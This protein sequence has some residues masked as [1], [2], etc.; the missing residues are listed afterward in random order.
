MNRRFPPAIQDPS[1]R[2]A[3]RELPAAALVLA[4]ASAALWQA[5]ADRA[6][7]LGLNAMA[8][9]WLPNWAPDALTVL[10]HGALACALVAPFLLIEPA[11]ALGVLAGALPAG[12]L[13]AGVKHLALRPRPA[14][15]LPLD[16][17]HIHGPVLSGHN[18]FPSGH[19]ITIFLVLGGLLLSSPWLRRHPIVGVACGALAA[20][21]AMSRVMVGAHWPSD[22]LAGAALGLVSA[23]LGRLFVIMW[24]SRADGPRTSLVLSLVILAVCATLPWVQTGYPDARAVQTLMAGLGCACASVSLWGLWRRERPWPRNP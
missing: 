20:A 19:S 11:A 7:F 22:V 16:R 5:D 24:L 6:V 13:S 8:A 4:V 14:A 12:I 17:I 3:W 18:S 21:V 10:G 23:A 9:L 2:A 15:V 1:E